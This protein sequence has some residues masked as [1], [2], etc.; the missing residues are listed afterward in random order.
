MD[1]KCGCSMTKQS[2]Q[3]FWVERTASSPRNNRDIEWDCHIRALLLCRYQNRNCYRNCILN[4]WL[5]ASQRKCIPH[6]YTI[7]YIGAIP[8]ITGPKKARQEKHFLPNP[9]NISMATSQHSYF[10]WCH[11]HN[12]FYQVF[13][14]S[15][16]T[17]HSAN[18]GD[19][20]SNLLLLLKWQTT[21]TN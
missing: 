10:H 8:S 2:H 14:K 16:T 12:R 9:L 5:L 1:S 19:Y 21:R 20:H 17:I 7:L 4:P 15:V 6:F 18:N 3:S 13:I 11:F